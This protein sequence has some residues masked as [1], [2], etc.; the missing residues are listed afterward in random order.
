MQVGHRVTCRAQ[1]DVR[2]CPN[3]LDLVFSDL[4]SRPDG[5]ATVAFDALKVILSKFSLAYFAIALQHT[6]RLFHR[7]RAK[8]RHPFSLLDEEALTDRLFVALL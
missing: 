2:L 1:I 7:F 8:I 6:S 4:V 5:F 3:Q